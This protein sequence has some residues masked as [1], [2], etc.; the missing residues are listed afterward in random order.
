MS[1]KR[2]IIVICIIFVVI[3]GLLMI[4]TSLLNGDT[5]TKVKKVNREERELQKKIEQVEK[6]K[7]TGKY[8]STVKNKEY[9]YLEQTDRDLVDEKIDY[10]LDLLVSR[11]TDEMYD[12]FS[13]TYKLA[14]FPSVKDLEK[15]LDE[16]F[17][18]DLKFVSKG[19]EIYGDDLYINVYIDGTDSKI[20]T[21]L[22]TNYNLS[23]KEK[24]SRDDG[25]DLQ[26][27][28]FL[29]DVSSIDGV[30]FQFYNNIV[31]LDSSYCFGYGDRY[32]LIVD[33]TNKTD[34]EITID[35]M[36]T[37]LVE[38]IGGRQNKYSMVTT[39]YLT[40]PAK[41]TVK[42][43]MGFRMFK[44]MATNVELHMAIGDK[45]FVASPSIVEQSIDDD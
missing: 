19:F 22:L 34:E 37:K 7:I 6:G 30:R 14:L 11:K 33:I 38:E 25:F 12:L 3:I 43:E 2:I 4:T 42:Y 9:Y 16:K 41:E 29:T 36:G 23:E 35:F 17:P 27:N 32:S 39:R 44:I 40:I 8:D 31:R 24:D 5:K 18:K 13:N 26:Q 28:L 21:L 15:Y 45:T 1:N 10:V 20:T